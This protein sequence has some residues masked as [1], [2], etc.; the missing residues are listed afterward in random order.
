MEMSRCAKRALV[1]VLAVGLIMIP[2]LAGADTVVSLDDAARV[3]NYVGCSLGIAGAYTGIGIAA[4]L[5]FC[6]LLLTEP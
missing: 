4:A 2:A 5:F 3:R 1:C 6:L